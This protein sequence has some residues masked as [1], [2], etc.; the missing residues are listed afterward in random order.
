[1]QDLAEE[2][3]AEIERINTKISE[4]QAKRPRQL[5]MKFKIKNQIKELEFILREKQ[6]EYIYVSTYYD[7]DSKIKQWI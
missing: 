4:L 2:Y 6:I 7:K 5:E 1:M 3:L